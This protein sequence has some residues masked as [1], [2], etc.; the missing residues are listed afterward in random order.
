MK[1]WDRVFLPGPCSS[2]F[3]SF[4]SSQGYCKIYAKE[5]ITCS[6]NV[7]DYS[8]YYHPKPIVILLFTL[9][10]PFYPSWGVETAAWP[11][12]PFLRHLSFHYRPSSDPL[13][14][15]QNTPFLTIGFKLLQSQKRHQGQESE[16]VCMHVCMYVC[17]YMY[18]LTVYEYIILLISQL[19]L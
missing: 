4:P 15:H 2:L 10:I 12:G 13:P 5:M 11:S 17:V 8:F 14:L 16:N 9:L 1:W 7:R 3:F 6:V 18:M 19:N